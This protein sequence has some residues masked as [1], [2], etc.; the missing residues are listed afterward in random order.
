MDCRRFGP[1]ARGRDA[2][3]DADWLVIDS[4]AALHGK[5]L[6]HALK[7]VHRVIM[8]IAPS[9]YDIQAS[10]DFLRDL[11]EFKTRAGTHPGWGCRYA[12]CAAATLE[13]FLQ[14][15]DLPVLTYLREAQIYVSAAF[16]G[17]SLFDSP[18]YQ[19]H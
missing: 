8:P 6:D 5:N 16:E 3:K 17:K 4:P 14:Q 18:P 19:A 9:R 7:L 13:Q 2:R 1:A 15:L 12:H 11:S 10:C